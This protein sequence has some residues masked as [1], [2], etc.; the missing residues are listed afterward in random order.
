MRIIPPLRTGNG[1][2]RLAGLR[3]S[4]YLN[5]LSARPTDAPEE[6]TSPQA[7]AVLGRAWP[8]HPG[9]PALAS[10]KGSRPGPTDVQSRETIVRMC[11]DRK[12]NGDSQVGQDELPGTDGVLDQ[13]GS[14]ESWRPD[15]GAGFDQAPACIKARVATK[16]LQTVMTIST[17][18]VAFLVHREEN[19]Q[20]PIGDGLLMATIAEQPP[21]VADASASVLVFAVMAP[22]RAASI[23]ATVPV[24][25]AGDHHL[26]QR[27]VAPP[28]P[29]C[30]GAA[31]LTCRAASWRPPWPTWPCPAGPVSSRRRV[32]S[33]P[34]CQSPGPGPWSRM[35]RRRRAA[36]ARRR[37]RT[38]WA[39]IPPTPISLLLAVPP[40]AAAGMVP[41][42]DAGRRGDA[43]GQDAQEV[44]DTIIGTPRL[45]PW[46]GA[47]SRESG[48]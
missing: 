28:P 24:A 21:A 26:V 17:G 1:R 40:V 10:Y 30:A 45:P 14:V 16:T 33:Q 36:Q 18:A 38:R 4:I 42:A 37:T 6:A 15:G 19:R 11:H 35:P 29:P 2:H 8:D 7:V 5:G 25:T 27:L 44:L 20:V 23:F 34:P 13:L 31:G 9:W 3:W 48:A 22:I 12:C 47:R 41:A 43:A 39:L 46:A 32:R